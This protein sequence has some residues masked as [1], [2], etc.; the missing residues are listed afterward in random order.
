MTQCTVA[1][2]V[3]K[4]W[5]DMWRSAPCINLHIHGFRSTGPDF[6]DALMEKWE[7]MEGFTTNLLMSPSAPALDALRTN[8]VLADD[9]RGRRHADIWIRR[10]VT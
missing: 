4:R 7:K 1:N 10:G 3:A 2:T 5:A 9:R 8:L 6:R